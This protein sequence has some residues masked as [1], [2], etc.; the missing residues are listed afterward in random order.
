MK[1]G[2]GYVLITDEQY[3]CYCRLLYAEF[4]RLNP[5]WKNWALLRFFRFY[6][7]KFF[8]PQSIRDIYKG[9]CFPWQCSRLK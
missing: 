3:D 2:T 9:I 5:R 8:G 1:N 6:R 7:Y 4:Q